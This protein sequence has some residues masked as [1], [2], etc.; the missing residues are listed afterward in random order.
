MNENLNTSLQE[1]TSDEKLLSLLSHLSLFLGGIVLPIIIWATQKD[2]SKFVRFHSL[3]SIFFHISIA[4]LIIVIVLFFLMIMIAG[5]GLHNLK[6][7]N[8]F[9]TMPGIFVALMI[10]FYGGLFLFIF[11][12][13][14]YSIYLAV[15]S[16]RGELIRIPFIGNF[17]YQRVYEQ[18]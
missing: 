5:F 16:Y 10:I 12:S 8:S 14:A 7:M 1:P 11:G 18:G 17:I 15:K 3:Q 6:H 2:K 4:V 13:F 9:D